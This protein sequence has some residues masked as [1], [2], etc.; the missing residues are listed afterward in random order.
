MFRTLAA[1]V[2]VGAIAFSYTDLESD[3]VFAS[4]ILP[5]IVFV[6]LLAL[7][8]WFVTFFHQRGI[9]QT[10]DPSDASGGAGITGCDGGG[11]SDGSC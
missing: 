10:A 7:A 3:S 11:G 5:F 2:V 4:T 1:I 9:K 8:L 6:A